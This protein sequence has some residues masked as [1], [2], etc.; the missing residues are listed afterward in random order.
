MDIRRLGS[1]ALDIC[2]TAAGI[3]GLYFEYGINA[4]DTA[5][6]V[7]LLREA[8]GRGS[9]LFWPALRPFY[10][11]EHCGWTTCARGTGTAFVAW[12]AVFS[13]KGEYGV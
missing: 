10:F 11:Q 3:F 13:L 1:A 7:C 9:G 2:Y 6:G 12:R 8:G 5:A 4:W